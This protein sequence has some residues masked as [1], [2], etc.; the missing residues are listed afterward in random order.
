M[1]DT[2]IDTSNDF[3]IDKIFETIK[4]KM[5]IPKKK[6]IVRNLSDEQKANI[7]ERLNKG[8]A[9]KRAEREA[10]QADDKPVKPDKQES[11]K[12][13]QEP[14]KPDAKQEPEANITPPAKKELDVDL[15]IQKMMEMSKF[16]GT[17]KTKA[18]A[19][20]DKQQ[21]PVIQEQPK[22]IIIKQQPKS[23]SDAQV[24]YN[25]KL[26]DFKNRMKNHNI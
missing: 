20:H 24:K 19:M 9:R 21:T 15:M 6:K 10:M 12:P 3:D 13:E 4:H 11:D 23:V 7:I 5:N 22:Q 2:N 8:K 18:D 26:L 1:S 25:K 14:V 17:L 16:M